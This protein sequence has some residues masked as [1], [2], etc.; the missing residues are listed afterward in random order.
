M[1]AGSQMRTVPSISGHMIALGAGHLIAIYER[2]QECY[3]AEFADGSG[4]FEYACSWF[5]FHA[6]ALRCPEARAA[7]QS[8]MPLTSEI[9]EKIARLHAENDARQERMVAVPRAAAAA[10]RRYWAWYCSQ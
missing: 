4:T 2:N 8:P 3:V 10:A 5:R 9:M 6:G 7:L 1:N